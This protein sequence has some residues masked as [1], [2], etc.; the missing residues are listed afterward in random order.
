V[1]IAT[2]KTLEL[3]KKRGMS[4]HIVERFIKAG[5]FGIRKDFLG[6]L[7]I[8]AIDPSTVPYKLLGAQSTTLNQRKEH[9]KTILE[10]QA[11]N[12]KLWLSTG[13]KLQLICWRK[14][15]KKNKDGGYSKIYIWEAKI[16]EITLD[17]IKDK[18]NGQ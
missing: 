11:E 6:I 15:K 9:L 13:S 2:Q 17:M 1:S 12:T 8:I 5:R 18:K 16:D 3:L 7:D 4:P 14:L 10:D